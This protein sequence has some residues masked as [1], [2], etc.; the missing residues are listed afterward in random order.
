MHSNNA[1]DVTV[2]LSR[3]KTFFELGKKQN[4]SDNT[5]HD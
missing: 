2:F 3:A 1:L 5:I 4:F